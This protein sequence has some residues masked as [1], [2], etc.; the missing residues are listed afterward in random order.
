VEL[1]GAEL[2][3]ST[4][5]T[6]GNQADEEKEQAVRAQATRE[7]K[8]ASDT[9]SDGAT[10][11]GASDATTSGGGGGATERARATASFFP[12]EQVR[13]TVEQLS[14]VAHAVVF[15][16]LFG[17][18]VGDRHML[19]LLAVQIAAAV[20][21]WFRLAK[22]VRSEHEMSA[23]VR[24]AAAPA[25]RRT[26][27]VQMSDSL[28]RVKLRRKLS[29]FEKVPAL[30]PNPFVNLTWKIDEEERRRLCLAAVTIFPLRALGVLLGL[31]LA[32]LAAKL[33]V[34]GLSDEELKRPLSPA[35]RLLVVWP[36]RLMARAILLAAGFYWIET[37]GRKAS[38]SEAPIIVS[39][40]ISFLENFF[41][42]HAFMPAAVASRE[43]VAMPLVGAV[44][45]GMQCILVDRT[46]ADSRKQVLNAILERVKEP[47]WPQTLIF[48]EGTTTNGRALIT[49]KKGAFVPGLP[50]QPCLLR[51]LV[52]RVDP[53][54]LISGP[55]LGSVI[56]RVLCEPAN[57]MSYEFLPPYAPSPAERADASLFAQ[58]VRQRMCEALGVESTDYAFEDV[59][60]QREALKLELP[61]DQVVVGF[62]AL[63]SAFQGVTVEQV[64]Q[65][66]EKFAE[67]DRR[68]RGR[69][70]LEEFAEA[71]GLPLSPEVRNLFAL[72]DPEDRGEIG[73]RE[74]LVGLGLVNA[75]DEAQVVHL[76]FR[77]FDLDGDGKVDVADLRRLFRVAFPDA[78]EADA[79]R[80][81]SGLRLERGR[82]VSPDEFRK[83]A[84]AHPECVE[85]FKRAF[86]LQ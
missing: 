72:L 53:S 78:S 51:V 9:E 2:L 50:V 20:F 30:P 68:G 52:S 23:A 74:Y 62:G 31:V 46:S 27:A 39:N 37:R 41:L 35:R 49:F 63:Q 84:H 57:W 21:T 10:P 67:F 18:F 16:Y 24:G 54:W 12:S 64:A 6:Q 43:N 44:V 15:L 40:H 36:V 82:L 47:G 25:S 42:V 26:G 19:K 38:A 81:L 86:K 70:S 17:S 65:R 13:R 14:L 32:A 7:S 73:F 61:P 33:G 76:A 45:R 29:S 85:V 80:L 58:N 69:L 60:L 55:S 8:Y 48:P 59:Q 1:D 71:F 11:T 79:E 22:Y 77:I 75:T 3:D 4:A 83:L 66:L 34:W 28:G 5:V 56:F